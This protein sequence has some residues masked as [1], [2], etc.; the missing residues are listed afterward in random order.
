MENDL[1][2]PWDGWTRPN[3]NWC[4]QQRCAY[5][6]APA[7]TY[8]NVAYLA[9]GAFMI[10]KSKHTVQCIKLFGPAAIATG[11][12]SGLYHASHTRAFQFLDFMGMYMFAFLPI[13][14]NGLRLG[15]VEHKHH[16]YLYTGAVTS[17]GVLT[18]IL[19]YL[20]F[21]IQIIIVMLVLGAIVT[22]YK[23]WHSDVQI[24]WFTAAQFLLAIA[25]MCSMADV[26]RLWCDPDH[27][28]QGHAIWHLLTAGSLVCSFIHYSQF[29]KLWTTDNVK[30][31][32][33]ISSLH[34]L[35]NFLFS[36]SDSP[37]SDS[38][39]ARHP[40]QA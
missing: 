12:G 25:S 20:E 23:A 33:R 3:I 17:L 28:V 30:R 7:N 16:R 26:T 18:L 27:V 15:Y 38:V 29:N 32:K 10:H 5:I 13:L 14:I 21:P 39:H 6:T 11:V 24:E 19:Q 8:S 37:V 9:A 36:S 40:R 34:D 22:E 35:E 1:D 4:E 31:L 2:C